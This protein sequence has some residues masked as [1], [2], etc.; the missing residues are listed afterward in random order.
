[1]V[2]MKMKMGFTAA[3]IMVASAVVAASVRTDAASSPVV[4]KSVPKG[5]MEDFEAARRQAAKEG[6]LILMDFSGSDWCGWCKK[7]DAEV[8][9]QDRFVKEASK[10]YVLVMIDSPNDRSILSELALAQNQNLKVRYAVRGFP[11]V[12]IVNPDGEVVARHSGYRKG[13]PNGY[14]KY[15]KELTKGVKW[16]TKGMEIKSIG[17]LNT[18]AKTE[19]AKTVRTRCR[20][21]GQT[22]GSASW[23]SS[24][25]TDCGEAQKIAHTTGKRILVYNHT[26]GDMSQRPGFHTDPMFLAY[27]TNR[28]VLLSVDGWGA[29]K[30]ETYSWA[31][32][33]GWPSCRVLDAEGKPASFDGSDRFGMWRLGNSDYFYADGGQMLEL[34]KGFDMARL[35]MA[36]V[37]PKKGKEPSPDELAKLHEVMS[38]LPETFVN[39]RYL[40]W[41][42]RL[43]AADPDCSRGYRGCYRYA[44][45]VYPRIKKYIELKRQFYNTLYRRVRELISAEGGDKSSGSWNMN[46]DI[47]YGELADGWIPKIS[48]S[49]MALESMDSEMSDGDSRF[50]FDI[51][52]KEMKNLLRTLRRKKGTPCDPLD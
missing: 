50:Q 37:L 14:M 42:E 27:A 16:P 22:T 17:I 9:S 29:D 13:G 10:K 39:W 41:A 20:P 5:W 48:E 34:L 52:K 46:M 24:W 11:S 44:A 3:L 43:V 30:K 26:P 8:F 49:V 25:L 40:K 31:Y 33:S 32:S 36:G 21:T 51:V 35:T 1:M 19:G 28:Y 18:N 38:V 15:L 7:M 6:K 2:C 4:S 23:R 45:E 12:V 47:A